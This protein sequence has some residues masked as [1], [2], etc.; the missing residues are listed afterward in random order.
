MKAVQDTKEVLEDGIALLQP[1]PNQAYPIWTPYNALEAAE[2][3]LNALKEEQIT[4][5]G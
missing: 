5:E 1:N 2:T 4:Y 3:L